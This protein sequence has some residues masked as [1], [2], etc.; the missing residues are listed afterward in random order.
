MAEDDLQVVFGAGQVGRSLVA[1]LAETEKRVRVVSRRRPAN[2]PR[3]VDWRP[4][5]AADLE[6][7]KN[8]ADGAAVI[9]QC[10][11][12]PYTNWPQQFPP[13]QR[14][15]LVAAEHVGALLVSLENVYGYGPTGGKPMTEDL[16]LAATS[17]KGTTRA[18]MTTELL[19]ASEEGESAS[20]SGAHPISLDRG[21]E[22]PAS[23]NVSSPTLLPAN[24]PISL[25][26]PIS[27]TRTAMF[28]TSPRDSSPSARTIGQ[29]DRS[30]ISL[31]RRRSPH[32]G[33]LK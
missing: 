23:A 24:A 30:G 28:L 19:A 18:A 33:S 4:A 13:L 1:R 2:L 32:E 26:T 15:V 7:A 21:S 6:S 3:Y 5:D 11:N 8:A 29:S 14:G 22:N 9:Y 27:S 31:D 25:E 10:L 16:P 12:A 20:R 17:N